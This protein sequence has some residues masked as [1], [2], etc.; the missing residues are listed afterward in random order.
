MAGLVRGN[1]LENQ[2]SLYIGAEI[3]DTDRHITFTN[4]FIQDSGIM[5]KLE[6]IL[7][8]VHSQGYSTNLDKL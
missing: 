8:Y 5:K 1:P 4:E 6:E 2:K 3:D 7:N